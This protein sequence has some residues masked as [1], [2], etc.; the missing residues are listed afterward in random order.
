MI[1]SQ[2]FFLKHDKVVCSIAALLIKAR[3]HNQDFRL[4]LGLPEINKVFLTTLFVKREF[5][6][7]LM[8]LYSSAHSEALN[9]TLNV[10]QS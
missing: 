8:W 4:S 1:K 3:D 10:F 7:L 9:E 6:L 2:M 5:F